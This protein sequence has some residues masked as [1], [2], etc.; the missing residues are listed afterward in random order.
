MSYVKINGKNV[1]TESEINSSFLEMIQ[2]YVMAYGKSYSKDKR[3]IISSRKI[4]QIGRLAKKNGDLDLSKSADVI[5]DKIISHYQNE[6][7]FTFGDKPNSDGMYYVY[8][9]FISGE[10]VPVSL[11]SAIKIFEDENLTP[12][13][14]KFE[15][16]NWDELYNLFTYLP[17]GIKFRDELYHSLYKEL[18]EVGPDGNSVS[19]LKC[20]LEIN[21]NFG[22]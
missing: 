19:K 14:V 18:D 2:R 17:S 1:L 7:E 11:D 20:K 10:G 16:D 12:G 21:I 15:S 8:V 6:A 4:Y 22:G 13:G 9:W 5:Y 3:A